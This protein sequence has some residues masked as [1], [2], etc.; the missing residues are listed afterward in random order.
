MKP[1]LD[2]RNAKWQPTLQESP[3][4]S[5]NTLA[6]YLGWL[7]AAL[8]IFKPWPQALAVSKQHLWNYSKAKEELRWPDAALSD[9]LRETCALQKAI[10]LLELQLHAQKKDSFEPIKF[11]ITF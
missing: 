6:D 9:A 7:S 8:S 3:Q 10:P 2:T 4:K 1:L 11:S 5:E